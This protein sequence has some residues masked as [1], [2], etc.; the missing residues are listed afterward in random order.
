MRKQIWLLWE[1]FRRL[2]IRLAGALL[3]ALLLFWSA[4]GYAF[5][6]EGGGA[7]GVSTGGVFVGFTLAVV[8]VGLLSAILIGFVLWATE[9]PV[10]F[11]P[12]GEL[13]G[14]K[15]YFWF[16]VD[17][18]VIGIQY[19]W[20]SFAFF[21][22]GGIM[23]L[24]VRWELAQPG[25]YFT[26]TQY[27]QFFTMHGTIMIFFF[28]IPMLVGA[29]GN[30]FVPLQIGTFDMAF[31]KLNALSYWLLVPA[32][33]LLIASYVVPGG[34]AQAGWTAYPPLSG[35]GGMGQV[36]WALSIFIVGWSSI[37]G[38]MNFLVTIMNMRT[39]GVGYFRLPLFTWTIATTAVL[40]VLG[41]A[42]LAAGL[43]LQFMS[44][45][46]NFPFFD[47]ARGGSPLM[48]QHVFWFYS[49]P[50]VYI[51]IL[52]AFGVI[53]EVLPVFSRK[54]LFGY[55]AMVYA[56]AGIGFLSFIVWAHHMFASAMVPSLRIPFML[57]T[58]LIAVP[59]GIKI[60]NWL[61]TI[62]FGKIRLDTAMLFSLALVS[63]FTIGGVSGVFMASVPVDLHLHDTYFVVAHIHYVLFGGSAF[64]IFGG[65][66][67]WFP[68][69]F[70]RIMDERL[71]KWHFL[72]SFIGFNLAFLPMHAVGTLGM[73]RRY[74]DY[75]AEFTNLNVTITIGAFLLGAAQLILI[76][77]IYRTFRVGEQAPDNPWGARTLEWFT[78]SPPPHHNFDQPL[79]VDHDPYDYTPN[80]AFPTP[81]L[82]PVPGD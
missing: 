35:Q 81:S 51:M 58:M 11:F 31:P 43:V 80:I 1:R 49:H 69:M 33:I 24:L 56:T 15:R 50:A 8:G 47:A 7:D 18:K 68:K 39:K 9:T 70:G 62:A 10:P 34:P 44:M 38:G 54:P 75:A 61:G 32:G 23:A 27:N 82:V 73:P 45:T 40:M 6:Q 57:T 66:Y 72:L 76:Y 22:L 29:F 74:A 37:V 55:R 2:N 53:S 17:H 16:S 19:F 64:A 25:M 5:A 36:L 30:Y 3:M 13:H 42:S 20:T 48:W 71:G 67:Y 4:G 28:I 65:I 60:F 79:T 41:T 63:M 12:Q 52:P 26:Q 78:T 59:S 77:N 46:M 14:W 21:I